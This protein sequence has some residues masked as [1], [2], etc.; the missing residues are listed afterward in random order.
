[1]T[2]CEEKS[3]QRKIKD[4]SKENQRKIKEKSKTERG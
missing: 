1:M 4:F 2:A 3:N